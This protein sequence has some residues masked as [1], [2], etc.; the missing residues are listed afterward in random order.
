MMR[1]HFFW[2]LCGALAGGAAMAILGPVFVRLQTRRGRLQARMLL[3]AALLV[4]VGCAWGLYRLWGT[5]DALALDAD[6][7]QLVDTMGHPGSSPSGSAPTPQG[8]GQ[9]GSVAE[10]TDRLA[11]RLQ[12][13]GGSPAD[14]TLLAQSYEFLGR[15]ADAASART[16]AD[17]PAA[18]AGDSTARIPSKVSISPEGTKLLAQAEKA[19][20]AHDYARALQAYSKADR[21]DALNADALANY[22]D[23]AAS[24]SGSLAGAPMH[25][26]ARA[27]ALDP[28]HPKALWLQAS[29]LHE[30]RQYAQAL[31]IWRNLA[32]VLPPDSA[33]RRIIAANIAEDQRLGGNPA[34]GNSQAGAG[35]DAQSGLARIQGTI[36]I[37]PKLLKSAG[38]GQALFVFA[39]A[40]DSPGP[41]AAV[42]RMQVD[43]WPVSFTLDDSQSMLPQRKLSDFGAVTIE[44]RISASGQALPRPGDL[45]GRTGVLDPRNGKPARILISEVT[46]P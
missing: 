23:V 40:K 31:T 1:E 21:L 36:D 19:R 12:A 15:S 13:Q 16:H 24:Q 46:G 39:R 10:V 25:Y 11:K 2:F 5:P 20:I 14:W 32:A 29:Y 3:A 41:P 38:A 17:V 18:A 44:A 4:A 42:K 28:R 9:I 6:E 43:K 7:S 8:G 34:G 33:D 27:L 37:D 22:A 26:L 45:Y 35:P 30:D